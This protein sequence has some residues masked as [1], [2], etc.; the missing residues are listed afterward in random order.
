MTLND[1]GGHF[2]FLK[3]RYPE[4]SLSHSSV[5]YR[6][7]TREHIAYSLEETREIQL[8]VYCVRPEVHAVKDHF[9]VA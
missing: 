2:S 8:P 5:Q 6:T 3:L 7:V 4:S 1:L 9:T